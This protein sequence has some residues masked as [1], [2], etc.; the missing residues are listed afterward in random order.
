MQA[1]VHSL[2]VSVL[3]YTCPLSST[4]LA[5]ISSA[6]SACRA[7]FMATENRIASHM[8]TAACA[9]TSRTAMKASH[10]SWAA[11]MRRRL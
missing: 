11:P 9:V 10:T 3:L 7:L 2:L 4:K 6:S 1:S 5:A 8:S